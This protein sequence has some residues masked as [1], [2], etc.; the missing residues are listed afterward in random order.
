MELL[1][2]SKLKFNAPIVHI[3][4]HYITL[5]ASA[6]VGTFMRESFV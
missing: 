3:T 1:S 4:L 5:R 2:T 6:H